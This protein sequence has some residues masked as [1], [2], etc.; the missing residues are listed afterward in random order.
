MTM[1]PLAPRAPY[2]TVLTASFSTSMDSMSYGLVPVRQP[3]F[4]P[5]V[6]ASGSITAPP[7]V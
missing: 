1:T 4:F 7:M 6:I 2:I 3:R 5:P